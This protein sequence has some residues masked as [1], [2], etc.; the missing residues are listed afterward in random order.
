MTIPKKHT[1]SKVHL[2]KI[3]HDRVNKSGLTIT[4]FADMINLSRPAVYQ[5]FNKH[6]IDSDLLFRI[7]LILNENFVKYLFYEIEEIV[8][9][10]EKDQETDFEQSM[11]SKQIS[12]EC[13]IIVNQ[14]NIAHK[15]DVIHQDLTKI[16]NILLEI[17]QADV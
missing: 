6:S 7:S 8:N 1:K 13:Y 15:L 9:Q 4:E 16:K 2:G 14:K 12:E 11:R 10:K 17:K 3:I 5:M